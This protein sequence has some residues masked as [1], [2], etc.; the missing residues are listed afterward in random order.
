MR[1]IA[2]V[3]V[4]PSKCPL[5]TMTHNAHASA[6]RRMNWV[7]PILDLAAIINMHWRFGQLHDEYA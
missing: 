7:G 6:L 4:Q 1:A 3:C 2:I 5:Y